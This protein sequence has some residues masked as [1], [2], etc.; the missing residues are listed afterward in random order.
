MKRLL[1]TLLACALVSTPAQ[2]TTA[3]ALTLTQQAKK[4]DVIIRATVGTPTTVTEGSVNYTVYP[5][6]V[7]ETIA[8]DAA[9]LPQNEGKPA[10]FFLQNL[11]DL[12]TLN[13]GQ[14]I[15]ALLYARRLDSPLVGFNQG[16]Y[17][18]VNGQVTRATVNGQAPT[19]K[20]DIPP[21][22]MGTPGN[23]TPAPTVAAPTDPNAL[24]PALSD[25]GKFR[26]ALR[27][28]RESK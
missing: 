6:T 18:I 12:P 23:P 15:I 24:D 17:L 10:L 22:N 9:T 5:L 25:L 21:V 14:D 4:A 7:T 13:N 20:P 1:P 28:A 11:S 3:P 27:A 2:A 26:D 19:P 8:G 16:L